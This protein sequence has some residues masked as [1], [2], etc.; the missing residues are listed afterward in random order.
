MPELFPL[1]EL[2]FSSDLQNINR[3]ESLV[4]NLRSELNLS[5]EIEAN[6]L[7]ALSEAVNNAI[8]HGNDSNAEKKVRLTMARKS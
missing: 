5:E 2:E 6:I 4:E 3:I 8:F 1:L 7:V